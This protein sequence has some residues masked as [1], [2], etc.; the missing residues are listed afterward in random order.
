LAAFGKWAGGSRGKVLGKNHQV[1]LIPEEE[2]EIIEIPVPRARFKAFH[3]RSTKTCLQIA[4]RHGVS[5]AFDTGVQAMYGDG[6][7]IWEL[8]GGAY[9]YEERPVVV[10]IS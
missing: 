8:E 5:K 10:Y 4:W 9:I 1:R 3:V 6:R 2:G 7:I